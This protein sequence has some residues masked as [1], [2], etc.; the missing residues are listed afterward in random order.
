MSKGISAMA[1]LPQTSIELVHGSADQSIQAVKA[2]LKKVASMQANEDSPLSAVDV[3]CNGNSP[4]MNATW[5]ISSLVKASEDIVFAT[6]LAGDI[7]TINGLA[8]LAVNGAKSNNT[9]FD[10][11]GD[12]TADAADL[13]DSVNNDVRIGTVAS[14][15]IASSVTD[16]ITITAVDSGI[17]GNAITLVEDTSGTTITIGAALLSGGVGF[18]CTFQSEVSN[19]SDDA[20]GRP[21]LSTRRLIDIDLNVVGDPTHVFNVRSVLA[22]VNFIEKLEDKVAETGSGA[23][24]DDTYT[25]IVLKG[26]TPYETFTWTVVKLANL[27]TL[28]PTATS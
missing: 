3:I 16:T 24:G 23:E 5:E 21:A 27:Y 6:V 19:L 14:G 9:E 12:D 25:D 26:A 4:Y 8:Y 22:C 13:I 1:F 11:S 20:K 17:G 28:T 10:M 18:Q 2:L 15:V 7:L